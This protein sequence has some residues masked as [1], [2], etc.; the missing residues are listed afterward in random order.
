MAYEKQNNFTLVSTHIY[1]QYITE[2]RNY[3]HANFW[4]RNSPDFIIYKI[5]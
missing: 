3:R 4:L 5:M 2:S 1:E